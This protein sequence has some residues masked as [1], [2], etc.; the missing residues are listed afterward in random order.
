MQQAYSF[1]LKRTRKN[2]GRGGNIAEPLC[3]RCDL[4]VVSHIPHH[5]LHYAWNEGIKNNQVFACYC[6]YIKKNDGSGGCSCLVFVLFTEDE[7][8]R[9]Y[10]I[11]LNFKKLMEY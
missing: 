4:G 11:A 6:L 2:P 8:V 10:Q 3:Y 1:L 9:N 7:E 5:S